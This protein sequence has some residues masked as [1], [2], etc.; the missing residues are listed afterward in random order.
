MVNRKPTD[1]SDF[2]LSELV[3][4]RDKHAENIANLTERLARIEGDLGTSESFAIFFE[5]KAGD[6][7]KLQ[8]VFL[9]MFVR[10][11]EKEESA[12]AAVEKRIQELDRRFVHKAWRRFGLGIVGV[13]VFV[14]GA[15]FTE[16][17]HVV[18]QHMSGKP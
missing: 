17:V 2:N 7:L 9:T 16:L 8:R 1:P 5:G 13:L 6:S 15:V 11:L 12:Q 3:S 18:A 14:L 10:F 4:S